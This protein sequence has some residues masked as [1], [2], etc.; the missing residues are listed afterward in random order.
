MKRFRIDI[1]LTVKIIF[2]KLSGSY[3]AFQQ[4]YL[5]FI[6]V[7]SGLMSEFFFTLSL[8]CKHLLNGRI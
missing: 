7:I 5:N 3:L 2:L 4:Y 6:V 8:L 1:E